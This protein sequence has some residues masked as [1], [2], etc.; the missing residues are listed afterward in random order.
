M[1]QRAT[2]PFTFAALA[3]AIL[4]CASPAHAFPGGTPPQIA[5]T[6]PD[7]NLQVGQNFSV[8]LKPYVTATDG[9]AFQIFLDDNGGA[10]A[11]GANLQPNPYDV[12]IGVFSGTATGTG[13]Y[14]CEVMA[15]DSDGWSQART[16][17]FV[18]AP[19]G[20][21]GGNVAAVPALGPAGLGLMSLLVAGVGALRRRKHGA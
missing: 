16:L 1:T 12:N 2:T 7:V 5:A 3:A 6:L 15:K 14:T 11:G 18:V 4:A 19:A 13:S 9:D 20:S 21:P 10:C 17:T 8:D